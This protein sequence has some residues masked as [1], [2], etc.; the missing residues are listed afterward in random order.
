MRRV[1]LL[2]LIC[3]LAACG[4]TRTRWP[5]PIDPD[6][7][8]FANYCDVAVEITVDAQPPVVVEKGAALYMSVGLGAR[9]YRFETVSGQAIGEFQFFA[10]AEFVFFIGSDAKC[11]VR[12]QPQSAQGSP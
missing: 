5:A 4:A 12:I 1:L 9:V 2:G 7:S 11:S 10:P 8:V 3:A 6:M